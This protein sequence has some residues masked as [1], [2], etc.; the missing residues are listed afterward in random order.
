MNQFS[1]RLGRFLC[2]SG[3]AVGA[4]VFCHWQDNDIVSTKLSFHSSKIPRGFDG[5]KIVHISDLHNKEFGHGQSRL[6]EKIKAENANAIFITG[7]LIDCRRTDVQ[8]AFDF[9]R[10]VVS[11]APVYY[12]P[13]NH[14]AKSGIFPELASQ[15][16][17][18]GVFVLND[19]AVKLQKNDDEIDLLGMRD[20]TFQ[21]VD[22][23]GYA[24]YLFGE[25][26][27]NLSEEINGRFTILLSHR[28]ELLPLY[29]ECG[30]HLVFSGHAHGGQ[31][32]LPFA[33]ALFAPNQGF[34]PAYT[35]GICRQHGTAMV[36][37]RGLGNSLLP[38]RIFNRPE[39]ISVTLKAVEKKEHN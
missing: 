7:D 28:P 12:V 15:L 10:G 14:E 32:R 2:L 31:F 17:E 11:L 38:Q 18:M 33:G 29:A 1:G 21:C 19:C 27:K 26:L 4:A 20:P 36:V 23:N 6:I 34:F 13:G 35:C 8:I 9:V 39:I 37:S 16:T 30:I 22:N 3:L 25:T 5:Y 24:C